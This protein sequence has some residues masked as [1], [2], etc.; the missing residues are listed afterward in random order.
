M[1]I[2]MILK[3]KSSKRLYSKGQRV[4]EIGRLDYLNHLDTSVE[5]FE[6]HRSFILLLNSHSLLLIHMFFIKVSWK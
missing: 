4:I 3:V 6:K 1:E 5:K 2:F